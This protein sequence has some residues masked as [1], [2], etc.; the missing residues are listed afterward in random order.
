[1]D[2]E[3]LIGFI[4]LLMKKISFLSALWPGKLPLSSSSCSVKISLGYGGVSL[5]G[6]VVLSTCDM[7]HCDTVSGEPRWVWPGTMRS[8][9]EPSC[10]IAVGTIGVSEAFSL[11]PAPVGGM[12]PGWGGWGCWGCWACWWGWWDC[13]RSGCGVDAD[14]F[15][16]NC[17]CELYRLG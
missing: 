2:F 5:D 17:T 9:L 12:S 6:Y 7:W 8:L 4:S 14:P 3:L 16:P 15:I 10:L 13:C 1:M 11:P